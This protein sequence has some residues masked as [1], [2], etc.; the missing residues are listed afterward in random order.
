MNETCVPPIISCTN[1]RIWNPAIYSCE[2]PPGTYSNYQKC[3][4]V[5][6]CTNGKV[7][8]PLNNLCNC[9]FGSVERMGRCVDPDCP[10]GQYWNGWEC[11][12]INC[13][14][15]S[16]FHI[17]KC[18]Y[19]GSNNCPFGHIWDGQKCIFY[20]IKCPKGTSWLN[21]KCASNQCGD[22]NYLG[23]GGECTPFSMQCPYPAFWNGKKCE[24]PT[25]GC[26]P[27]TFIQ[28]DKC[29]PY[30]PCKNNFVWDPAYLRC[31]CRPGT[32]NS[33]NTCIECPASKIWVPSE[34]CVCPEGSFD[35]G[36]SCEA[37]TQNRCSLIANSFWEGE[38]CKCRPGFTKVD[39]SCICYGTQAGNLCDKCSY[40]PNSEYNHLLDI[41]QCRP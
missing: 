3:D 14:P 31:V 33:G 18:V 37:L 11:H 41:C 30:V 26:P 28:G 13:P 16:Y 20:P 12:I 22:G 25:K 2:C 19:G 40:K 9:P 6:V 38:K 8:N 5:P 35:A 17:N 29:M 23:S 27:H 1:G 10:A 21:S 34:G 32:I 24:T 15:P 39:F 7:Y 36:A 4:P